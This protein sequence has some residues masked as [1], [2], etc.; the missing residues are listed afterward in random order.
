MI[1]KATID[2]VFENSR[3]E[4]VIG[5][6]I[7]LK[8]SGSNYKGLS[9]FTDEKT[10]SFMVSPVKQIWKD[11]SS[12]KGGNVI[13]FLMEHEHLNYP[14]AIRYLAKKYN[15]EILES[16]VNSQEKKEQS[17]KESMFVIT[18][19]ALKYFK[20]SLWESDEGKRIAYSYL[21]ERLFD[22]NII[23]DFDI[24]YCPNQKNSFST[25]AINEGYKEELLEKTGLTIIN[26]KNKIDRFS[27]RVIFPIHSISGRVLGFGAR[28]LRNDKKV[29]KYLNSIESSIYLKSKILYGLYQSK[30]SIAQED[31]CYVVEGYTD[32]IQMF[33]S[34]I[35]NVVSS[36]GTSL[37]PNQIRLISRLT[38]NIV[39]LFDSDSA[40]VKAS[41]RGI[42]IILKEG[43]NVKVCSFPN[44]E[45]PDSFVKDKSTEQIKNFLASESKDFI[46]YKASLLA[47]E[48]KDEPLNKSNTV[49][50][51]VRSIANIPDRIKQE[52]YL[53]SCSKLMN[54]S[55]DVLFSTLAQIQNK[56]KRNLPKN[57]SN[58]SEQL[59][60]TKKINEV[61]SRFE[62][63]K[64]IIKLLLFHGNEKVVLKEPV[65]FKGDKTGKIKTKDSKVTCKVY[66]KIY[67]DL[68]QDEIAFSTS[69]FKSLY[70]KIIYS[71]NNSDNFSIEKFVNNLPI[72]MSKEVSDIILNED[73]Y[74]LHDWSKKNIF[75]AKKS[76]LLSQWVFEIILRFRCELIEE[77]VSDLQNKTKQNKGEHHDNLLEEIIQYHKLKTVLSE[78]LN[79]VI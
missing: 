46:Q 79:K 15:I 32:V 8:K 13:A 16:P 53:Q 77:K 59:V 1:Q 26:L 52:L 24:G 72:E 37:T 61:N 76:E 21:K 54:V 55:E 4:E 33:Q 6:F 49:H 47:E 31:L 65:L 27:G 25:Y 20:K 67:L 60:K 17:E 23:K 36:S 22:D 39:I 69:I 19:F 44:G 34:G 9:P 63:E 48:I 2:A 78:R 57:Y 11:F 41:L 5:D 71:I 66:E 74:Y 75:V 68:Q 40:G 62:L 42:D 12:G 3:V 64:N 14:E 10:P 51:I 7:N 50:D 29:A 18:E 43:L 56:S 38:K 58:T 30:Q 28:T 73:Q 35:K 45:D 70:E